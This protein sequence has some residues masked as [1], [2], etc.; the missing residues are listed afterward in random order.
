MALVFAAPPAVIAGVVFRR[1]FLNAPGLRG[2]LLGAVCGLSG[3]AGIHSHCA[4]VT[5]SHVLVAHGASIIACGVIG[6]LL[7]SR[8]GESSS[9]WGC[10][11]SAAAEGDAAGCHD[12]GVLAPR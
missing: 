1:G 11:S 9:W 2:A 7:G 6:A 12:L 3:A 8:F 5:F 10:R 4:V